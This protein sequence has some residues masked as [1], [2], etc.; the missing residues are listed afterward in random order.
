M[1]DIYGVIDIGSNTMRLSCYCII[2]GRLQPLFCK[3]SV[4]GLAGYVDENNCLSAEGIERAITT[5]ETFRN[6]IDSIGI[7]VYYAIATASLRNVA[8]TGYIVDM[9]FKSTGIK[10]HVLFGEEE[11]TYDFKG[12][13]YY[14][15]LTK[16]LVIDIGGGSTE[17]VKFDK[18]NIISA[19]SLPIG[20]LN[21]YKKHVAG[22]FPTKEEENEL[23][24]KLR[25]KLEKKESESCEYILGVGGTVRACTKMYN[26]FFGKSSLNRKMD[27][28]KLRE[29]IEKA[30][31][32]DKSEIDRIL[33]IAPERV[34]TLMPGMIILDEVCSYFSVKHIELSPGGVREG[35][36]ID[37]ICIK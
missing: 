11:A 1:E 12:T 2:D 4:A 24:T 28:D 8:N 3:K 21:S 22:L 31:S 10:V 13:K 17:I 25:S 6:M 32:A 36:M 30:L 5:L 16:G 15:E 26:D 14:S 7:K 35:Y 19:K 37:K 27:Y 20:S 34:H 33:K 9:I 29:M 23:R 18:R